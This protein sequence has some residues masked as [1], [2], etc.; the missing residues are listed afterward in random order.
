ML[1]CAPLQIGTGGVSTNQTSSRLHDG[2]QLS[3]HFLHK[4]LART[5]I[6]HQMVMSGG[7]QLVH[8]KNSRFRSE[9]INDGMACVFSES[10]TARNPELSG[11]Q[12]LGPS[13]L[14][15]VPRSYFRLGTFQCGLTIPT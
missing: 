4:S 6:P 7:T 9:F 5:Q 8:T 15:A 10:E 11:K 2:G 14:S 1:R 3:Y 12:T 13:T